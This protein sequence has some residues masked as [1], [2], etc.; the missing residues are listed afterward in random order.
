MKT[1]ISIPDYLFK[2]VEHFS[3]KH[4]RSRSEVFAMAVKTLLEKEKTEEL[5]VAL[6]AA[7]T[8]AESPEE[9][10]LRDNSKRYYQR[11]II[12]EE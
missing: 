9:T 5:L 3:K 10:R 4:R 6:N 8:E 7:Y 1:A 2:E 11:N 12:K